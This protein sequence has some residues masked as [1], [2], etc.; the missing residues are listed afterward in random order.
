MPETSDNYIRVSTVLYPF[1]GLHDVDQNIVANAARRGTKVHKICESIISGLGEIGVDEETQGYVDSF[2]QW[3]D[4]GIDVVK[5]EERFWHEELE[6]T[7]Q[8]DLLINTDSG[9][10]IVD[11]KTSSRPSKTWPVQG[12]AYALLAKH[13]GY[14]IKHIYFLHLNK[15]GKRAKIHEYEVDDSLFLAVLRTYRH[16]YGKD[17]TWPS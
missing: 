12:S 17:I 11:L 10:A 3:W 1:S 8:V 15:S 6:V 9:L 4:T 2:K 5:M 7:G 14:D 16:F 13:C